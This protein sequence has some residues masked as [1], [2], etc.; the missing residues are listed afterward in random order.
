MKK[1]FT[2]AEVLV[3]MGIIGVV[4]AMTVPTLMQNYQRDSFVTQLHKVYSEVLQAFARD[5]SDSHAVRIREAGISRN[6]AAWFLRTYFKTVKT[7]DGSNLSDCFADSYQ[8]LNGTNIRLRD[9]MSSGSVAVLA[10]G[11]VIYL[12]SNGYVIFDVNGK[13]GPNILGRDLFSFEIA[14][15]GTLET[16]NLDYYVEHFATS[17]QSATVTYDGGCFAKILNDGWK[18][19]Y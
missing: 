19:D 7:C 12:Q 11:A 18:M 5:M 15:D 2:L 8:N 9:S 14:N 1:G 17:C 10:S 4:A 3:T 16:S 6:G 13:Q